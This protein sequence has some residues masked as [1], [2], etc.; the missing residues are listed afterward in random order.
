MVKLAAGFLIA[1]WCAASLAGL[2]VG[3]VGK[4]VLL[5]LIALTVI[6]DFV[7]AEKPS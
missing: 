7:N 4:Y 6:S 5:V 3:R 1:G 2:Y